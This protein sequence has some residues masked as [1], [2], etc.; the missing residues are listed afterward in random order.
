[1][2]PMILCG[3]NAV[4]CSSL[5]P[6]LRVNNSCAVQVFVWAKA[7]TAARPVRT[8]HGSSLRD[9]SIMR[10]AYHDRPDLALSLTLCVKQRGSAM[11]AMKILGRALAYPVHDT[12]RR[13]DI[14]KLNFAGGFA[15]GVGLL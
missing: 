7:M 12:G 13:V 11:K 4:R 8:I 15:I 14:M 10:T 2:L 5:V 3:G 6:T 9:R 1:M